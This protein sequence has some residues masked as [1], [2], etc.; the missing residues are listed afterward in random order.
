MMTVLS[1]IGPTVLLCVILLYMYYLI[2]NLQDRVEELEAR[3]HAGAPYDDSG[4]IFREKG[5][6][7]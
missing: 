2:C 3:P 7:P 4:Y 1:V 6:H 5:Y